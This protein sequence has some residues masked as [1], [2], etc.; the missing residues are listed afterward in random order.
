MRKSMQ[1]DAELSYNWMLKDAELSYNWMLKDAELSYNWMLKDAELSYNWMLK[2]S[3]GDGMGLAAA[4]PP[5]CRRAIHWRKRRRQ[6]APKWEARRQKERER[7]GEK[8]KAAARRA[9]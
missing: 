6:F 1:E 2:G 7:E 3:L 4:T 5:Q 9:A 8:K